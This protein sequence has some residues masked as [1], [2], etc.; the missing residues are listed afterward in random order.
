VIEE[1]FGRQFADN[2]TPAKASG[3]KLLS[4]ASLQFGK[5][6]G[7][8]RCAVPDREHAGKFFQKNQALLIV[9][10]SGICFPV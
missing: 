4:A 8:R 7:F 3:G 2:M 9:S 6:R 5:G 1:K 10:Q